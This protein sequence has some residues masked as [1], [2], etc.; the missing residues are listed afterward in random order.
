MTSKNKAIFSALGGVFVVGAGV[1]GWLLWDKISFAD[2]VAQELTDEESKYES[3]RM[4]KVFPCKASLDSIE[5]NK[6]N[7]VEWFD[8]SMK[9]VSK[10]DALPS[11]ETPAAFKQRLTSA[12]GKMKN[13]E[14][15][16][17]GRIASQTFLFGFDQYLGENPTMPSDKDVPRLA[18]ELDTIVHVVNL[19]SEAGI[20]E[21]KNITRMNNAP[22]NAESQQ[23][24]GR[25]RPQKKKADEVEGPKT[26]VLKYA[27]EFTTRP[28][29]LVEAINMLSADEKFITIT[30]FALRPTSD[31]IT[32]K[33]SASD[34]AKAT[35]STG[36]RRRRGRGAAAAP[37]SF[38]ASVE[39][40]ESEPNTA[41]QRLVVDPESD[42]PIYVT[43][44]L[45]VT[46]FGRPVQPVAAPASADATADAAKASAPKKEDK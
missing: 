15:G 41:M 40:K 20:V 23:Q 22:V 7:Y 19:L 29:G 21:V 8:S 12:V 32:D 31:T 30:D 1:L 44:T 9:A 2:Q 28:A 35:Q 34:S 16:L 26:T 5:T 6:Q 38:A 11:Q 13:L 14:G 10:A 46:D 33:F 25:R 4:S 39:N 27:L 17:D 18:S 42:A 3:F 43:M 45:T 37:L 24:S 36:G